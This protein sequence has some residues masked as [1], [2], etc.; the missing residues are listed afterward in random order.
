M[1][2]D[3]ADLDLRHRRS[4]AADYLLFFRARRV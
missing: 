2:A 1:N 4:S 3:D